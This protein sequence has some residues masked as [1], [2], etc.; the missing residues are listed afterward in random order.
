[1]SITT[2]HFRLTPE[3]K[4]FK[5]LLSQCS[6]L[7]TYWD[8]EKRDCDIE[9]LRNDLGKLSMGEAIMARFLS[10]VWFGENKLDFDLISAAKS[11][12][13][14]HLK[15]ITNWLSKPDFP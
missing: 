6:R 7:E 4:R 8:F 15:I 11:L 5:K 2:G 1:M 14:E 10:A 9:R 3:Q 12:D 13:P